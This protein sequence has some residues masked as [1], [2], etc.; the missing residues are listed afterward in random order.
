MTFSAISLCNESTDLSAGSEHS[1]SL[2]H[3]RQELLCCFKRDILEGWV[4]NDT[5]DWP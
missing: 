3:G 2:L 4:G 5:L 1:F